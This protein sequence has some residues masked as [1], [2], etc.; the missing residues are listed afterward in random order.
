MQMPVEELGDTGKKMQDFFSHLYSVFQYC[1][2]ADTAYNDDYMPDEFGLLHN[3]CGCVS[4]ALQQMIGG[5][6]VR[7]KCKDIPHMWNRLGKFQYDLCAS[8]YGLSPVMISVGIDFST[9][10][11]PKTFN[12]KNIN[13]RFQKFWSRVQETYY[14]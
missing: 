11:K 3:H 6:V 2:A 14:R 7:G 5:E 4:Y 13:P 12:P 9:H 1:G 8:Q 10:T